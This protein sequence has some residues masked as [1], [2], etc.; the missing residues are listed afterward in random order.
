MF[1]GY[2]ISRAGISP[3]RKLRRRM[4]ARVKAAAAQGDKALIRTIRSYQG[5]LLFP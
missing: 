4:R 1:V 5:L 2:R 3:S